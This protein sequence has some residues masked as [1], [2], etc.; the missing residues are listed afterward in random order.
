[1]MD[2]VITIGRKFPEIKLNTSYSFG[3]DDSDFSLAFDTDV[4]LRFQDLI[5]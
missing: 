1:M 4:L 3:I 2:E 5:L